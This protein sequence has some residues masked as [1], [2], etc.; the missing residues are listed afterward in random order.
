MGKQLNL[1]LDDRLARSLAETAARECR[2]PHD[3]ARYILLQALGITD[4]QHMESSDHVQNRAGVRQDFT[5]AV[6]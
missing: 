4:E 5:S 2:R 3:Q 1:Y 6:L